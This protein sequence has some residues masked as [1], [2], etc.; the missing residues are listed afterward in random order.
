VF[1]HVAVSSDLLYI[2]I[3]E[4]HGTISMIDL[5]EYFRLFP[6][7]ANLNFATKKILEY[8]E[9]VEPTVNQQISIGQIHQYESAYLTRAESWRRSTILPDNKK[10]VEIDHTLC[11]WYDVQWDL[12]KSSNYSQYATPWVPTL[13]YHI[14]MRLFKI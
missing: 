6:S 11:H 4:M 10:E 7:G 3:G 2:S 5:D 12:D 8:D 14:I 13:V 1:S 9:D